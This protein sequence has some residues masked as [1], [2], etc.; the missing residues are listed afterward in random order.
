MPIDRDRLKTAPAGGHVLV[1]ERDSKDLDHSTDLHRTAVVMK[2]LCGMAG[3]WLHA[4]NM[5]YLEVCPEN[6]YVIENENIE[7]TR[8]LLLDPATARRVEDIRNGKVE[9]VFSKDW[10]APEQIRWDTEK[11]SAKSDIYSFGA[12]LF[13]MLTFRE[14]REY[15]G[16]TERMMMTIS[17]AQWS[18]EVE[19][20]ELIH[21]MLDKTLQEDPEKRYDSLKEMEEDLQKMIDFTSGKVY[22]PNICEQI[23]EVADHVESTEPDG[24]RRFHRQQLMQTLRADRMAFSGLEHYERLAEK[25][26]PRANFICGLLYENG[27]GTRCEY[28]TA[29]AYY[30]SAK[31][32]SE[33]MYRIGVLCEDRRAEFAADAQYARSQALEWYRKSAALG[34]VKAKFNLASLLL[35]DSSKGDKAEGEKL[36]KE[37]ADQGFAEAQFVLAARDGFKKEAEELLKS[38][39][40]QDMVQAKCL[41]G[42][43]Y[44][45]GS[46][47]KKDS[48]EGMR[49]IGEAAREKE[50]AAERI[51]NLP[52]SA[53]KAAAAKMHLRR[54]KMEASGDLRKKLYYEM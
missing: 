15:G 36:L 52:G 16:R 39:A 23:E 14:I 4:K 3:S 44:L 47:A 8:A 48:D 19:V 5:V 30:K 22:A 40:E 17:K 51:L 42:C 41:L 6:V 26:D 20:Q 38:A 12:L 31:E 43:M 21:K 25:G 18:A 10:S 46:G 27:L 1:E 34:H 33:A 2:S 45:T 9:P 32:D 24:K 11:I 37:A 7:E 49:W 29:I 13:W 50:P 28:D 53:A 54:M 35:A